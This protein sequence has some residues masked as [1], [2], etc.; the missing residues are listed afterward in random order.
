MS[1][2]P[3]PKEKEAVEA[4]ASSCLA[5]FV[6]EHKETLDQKLCDPDEARKFLLQDSTLMARLV[7]AS[8][9]DKWEGIMELLVEHGL[10]RTTE[11]ERVWDDQDVYW[12][13]INSECKILSPSPSDF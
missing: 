13:M 6:A 10:S 4:Y 7:F 5:N 1:E 2:G 8:I 3:A 11:F 12:G 9:G